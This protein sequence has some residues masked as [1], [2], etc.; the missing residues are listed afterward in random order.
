MMHED[1]NKKHLSQEIKYAEI[2]G[3]ITYFLGPQAAEAL[4]LY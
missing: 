1:S 4:T 2:A 3:E